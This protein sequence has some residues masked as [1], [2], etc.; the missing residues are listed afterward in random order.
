MPSRVD[1]LD[2][3]F[4]KEISNII[5]T[6]LDMKKIGFC[7]VSDVK[8]T[9]DLSLAR[10]YVSF[11]GKNYSIQE[12]RKQKG[13]IRKELSHRLS[14]RK[15]PDLEFVLDDTLEK[16]QRIEDILSKNQ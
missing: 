8:I 9:V 13:F 12:L 16:A 1:K 7:T 10:V 15:M 3:L 5:M 6:E 11:L 4:Q 14:M 2:S